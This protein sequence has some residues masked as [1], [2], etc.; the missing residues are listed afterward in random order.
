MAQ[1]YSEDYQIIS[2]CLRGSSASGTQVKLKDAFP[3][4]FSIKHEG[5]VAEWV[6]PKD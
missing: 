3:H 1:I 5:D 6:F 2:Y 4:R